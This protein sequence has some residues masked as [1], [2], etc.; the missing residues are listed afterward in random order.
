MRVV[1][2]IQARMGSSRLPGKVM[3]D[4]A[5]EPMLR[6]DVNRVRRARMLDET[7]IATTTELPDDAIAEYCRANGIAVFRGSENDVLDRYCRAAR[8][9]RADAVV[10][11]TSD[12][13]LIDPQLIDEVIDCFVRAG[14]LDYA[15]NVFPHR[16]YP[17]GLDTEIV[18]FDVL[19]RLR[20]R[21][22]DRIS[23]EHVTAYIQRNPGQFRLA[24]TPCPQDYSHMRWTVDTQE[25]YDLVRRVYEHFGHDEFSWTDVLG[26]LERHPDWLE[27]NRDVRQKEL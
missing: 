7:L 20:R 1:A 16:R 8:E 26:L 14:D 13:P 19:E 17:R 21:T 2:I 18:R 9:H 12:C 3:L 4:L 10:R 15:S 22:S 6:R 25:D 11:I 24:C 27:L 5:G 23:R